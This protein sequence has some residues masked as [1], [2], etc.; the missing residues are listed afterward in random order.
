MET[1]MESTQTWKTG[2]DKISLQN[3]KWIG[4]EEKKKEVPTLVVSAKCSM[5]AVAFGISK[6][7]MFIF[8]QLL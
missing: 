4:R 2:S 5:K 3:A 7:A 1:L 6:V 8:S